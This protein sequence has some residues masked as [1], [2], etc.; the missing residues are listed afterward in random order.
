MILFYINRACKNLPKEQRKHL[1]AA[2]G[3]LRA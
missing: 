3:K 1:E 2:K